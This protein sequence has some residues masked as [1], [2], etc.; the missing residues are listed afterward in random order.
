MNYFR[1]ISLR[2]AY[3]RLVEVYF[4]SYSALGYLK[5]NLCDTLSSNYIFLMAY[6]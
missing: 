2:F 3:S 4:H 6:S 5:R 1:F